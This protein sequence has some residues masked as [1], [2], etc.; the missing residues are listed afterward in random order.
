M[1]R[2]QCRLENRHEIQEVGAVLSPT[3]P[4]NLIYFGK[5]SRHTHAKGCLVGEVV[6]QYT[7]CIVTGAKGL[8]WFVL[9]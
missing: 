8:A 6:S 3:F 1:W 2:K 5:N 4:R 7:W 9:Q